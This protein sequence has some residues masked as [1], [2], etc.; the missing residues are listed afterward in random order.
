[1]PASTF[2]RLSILNRYYKITRFYGFLK[3]LSVKTGIIL[4]ALGAAFVI[5]EYF[6]IDTHAIL[7]TINNLFSPWYIWTIFYLSETLMGFLPPE[8]FIAWSTKTGNQWANLWILAGA[9]YLGGLSA[10]YMGRL[11]YR[12]KKVRAYL[13]NKNAKNIANL[14]RWGGLFIFVG[15]ML[16]VPHSIVSFYAGMI[17]YNIKNYLLWALFRFLRF[18]LYALVIFH[19]L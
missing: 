1:M 4:F 6:F 15:A 18:Y 8:A 7:Q 19:V 9:S 3:N 11:A 10:F 14:K 16:P 13:E 5:L 2:S 17:G 12:F